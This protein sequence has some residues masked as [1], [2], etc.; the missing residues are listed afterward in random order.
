MC[1]TRLLVEIHVGAH[2]IAS[3][4]VTI[5][6]AHVED[7]NRAHSSLLSRAQS[8]TRQQLHEMSLLRYP[9]DV[10]QEKS[11]SLRGDLLL[12]CF[13]GYRFLECL[14][15]RLEK[16]F[17]NPLASFFTDPYFDEGRAPEPEIVV[18]SSGC[19]RPT[20]GTSTDSDYGSDR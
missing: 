5:Q 12:M 10:K 8:L 15:A 1:F 20:G 16:G 18:P 7:V 17:H 6:K 14:F 3:S 4:F 2:W 13:F 19:H 11:W 9:Q